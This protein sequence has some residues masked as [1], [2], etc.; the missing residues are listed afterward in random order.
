MVTRLDIEE[1]INSRLKFILL[2]GQ[3]SL[4]ESQ[5]TAFRKLILDSLGEKG[6]V[7]DLERL[8]NETDRQGTGGNTLCR[9]RGAV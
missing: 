5:F 4:S 3:S 7:R 9:R 1:I 8:F 6:L 2:V